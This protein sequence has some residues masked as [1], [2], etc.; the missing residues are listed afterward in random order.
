MRDQFTA[1]G[2]IILDNALG[3]WV[4]RVYL[5]SRAAMY[6]RFRAHGVEITPEQW[7][8]LVRLWEQEGVTQTHL[9]DRTFRDVPTMSRILAL[10]ERD[11]LVARRQDPTDRRARLVYLTAHGRKLRKALSSEAMA[12]VDA[13]RA[14]I[15]E[16]DLLTTRRTLQRLLANLEPE[17]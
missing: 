3:Y 14:G 6:R 9:A 10:M 12:L 11:G 1:D 2:G 8:V 17:G 5:A 13:L 16:D 4:S 7:M 15:P